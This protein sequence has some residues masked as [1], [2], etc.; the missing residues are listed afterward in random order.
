MKQRYHLFMFNNGKFANSLLAELVKLN[1]ALLLIRFIKFN[2][3]TNFFSHKL[4]ITF[5]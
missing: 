1:L 4:K 5:I 3:L 2:L